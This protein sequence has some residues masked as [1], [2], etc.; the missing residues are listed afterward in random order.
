MK[1][2]EISVLTPGSNDYVVGVTVNNVDARFPISDVGGRQKLTADTQF[3]VSVLGSDSNSGSATMPWRTLQ[4][5]MDFIAANLDIAGFTITVNIGAGTFV[6][7]GLRSTVGGGRINWVGA[8][9]ASTTITNGNNDGINNAGEGIAVFNVIQTVMSFDKCTIAVTNNDAID[10]FASVN[11]QFASSD[12]K[13]DLTNL[14]VGSVMIWADAAGVYVQDVALTIIGGGANVNEAFLIESGAFYSA[15]TNG[16][17]STVSGNLTIAEAFVKADSGG[18]FISG[19]VPTGYNVTG[20]VTGVRFRAESHGYIG[21]QADQQPLGLTYFPGDAAGV[22]DPSSA[23]D[24]STL[25]NPQVGP[26]DS[27]LLAN[28]FINTCW[29]VHKDVSNGPIKLA[30]N[31]S[32]KIQVKQIGRVPN[33]QTASY[34]LQLFDQDGRV[35]MNVAGANNL[36]VPTNAS[37]SFP[38][39]T[40]IKITQVGAGN[41]TILAAGGVTGHNF[42]ALSGQWASVSLYQRA[43]NEWVQTNV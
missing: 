9:S 10:I 36:T 34:T 35:E 43:A 11:L 20:T 37:V 30:A 8:G 27:T 16:A 13:F 31:D 41:T 5:A 22:I 14:G 38:V 19:A 23:Y 17:T 29:V 6:G 3:Y 42:G 21:C 32:G 1:L 28:H 4:H 39:G 18:I 2:S 40:E 25:W 26:P 12:V 15:N 33:T 24:N 7:L